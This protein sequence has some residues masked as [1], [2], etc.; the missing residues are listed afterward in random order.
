[1]GSYK[2]GSTQPN[3]CQLRSLFHLWWKREQPTQSAAVRDGLLGVLPYLLRRQRT[4]PMNL[5]VIIRIHSR[6]SFEIV[7][8][9]ERS[10]SWSNFELR[11][12]QVE[13]NPKP[14]TPSAP[15]PLYR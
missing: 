6:E 14:E 3:L 7:F 11:R 10:S 9:F 2:W 15:K 13:R 4:R 12:V 5:Q 8:R 1:M